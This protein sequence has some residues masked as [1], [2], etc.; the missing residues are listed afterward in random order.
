[1]CTHSFNPS[2]TPAELFLNCTPIKL[3]PGIKS[4]VPHLSAWPNFKLCIHC[5]SVLF[6]CAVNI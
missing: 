5:L 3:C 6:T 4:V 2:P 1:M